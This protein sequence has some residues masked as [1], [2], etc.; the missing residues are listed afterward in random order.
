MSAITSARLRQLRAD[1]LARDLVD[2]QE[3][4]RRADAYL[5]AIAKAP[6]LVLVWSWLRDWRRYREADWDVLRVLHRHRAE[7][8]WR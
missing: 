6:R 4:D 1:L 8:G 3:A 7:E 5:D 2:R